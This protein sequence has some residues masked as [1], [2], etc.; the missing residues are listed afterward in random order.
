MS[1]Y[2]LSKTLVMVG[3]MGAGKTAVGTALARL[4]GVPFLD[5]DSQIEQAANMSVGEI[6][7]TYGEAFFREK[8]SLVLAR[9]LEGG[10]VVLST[11][12]GAFLQKDNQNMIAEKGLAVW[13]KADRE[14]LWARVR[15]KST[16]PLLQVAN[17]KER[18]FELLDQREP[19]YQLAGEVVLADPNF[20]ISEMAQNVLD[21]LLARPDQILTKVS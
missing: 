5:S 3:M 21:N 15:H 9:L 7:E 16:R 17:P 10:P 12:G 4:I 6:F 2:K 13:L 20:S 19:V 1:R 11:G 18:L 14:L 8:E